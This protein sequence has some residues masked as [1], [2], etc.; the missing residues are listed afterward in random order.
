VSSSDAPS[1]ATARFNE[2]ALAAV[3]ADAQQ[4]GFLG[5]RPIREAI[6]H[7]R[8]VVGALDGVSGRVVDLGAGGG[9]PGLVVAQARPD[10]MLTLIDRRTKRTDFLER[11]VRRHRLGDRVEVLAE[12]VERL[13]DHVATG[14]KPSFDAAVAR[15]FGPPERTLRFM[16]GLGRVG[17]RLVITEP[18]EGDR[19]DPL[20]LEDAGVG[21]VAG[22]SG[23]V[24]FEVR[25]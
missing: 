22:P 15:G 19:W 14:D 3:L 7:A 21:R 12:D 1:D 18:P 2:T 5:S 20:L 10:L 13:L 4:L 6:Q 11:V 9:I 17:S 8:S 25:G 23:V 16:V 24:V